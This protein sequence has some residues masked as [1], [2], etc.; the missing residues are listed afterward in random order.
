MG[1]ASGLAGVAFESGLEPPLL[2][3]VIENQLGDV[4]GALLASARRAMGT[5]QRT[6]GAPAG[7]AASGGTT[8]GRGSDG[9]PGAWGILPSPPG[10]RLIAV[11]ACLAAGRI[12]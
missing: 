10:R 11:A 5:L 7:E 3:M 4:H 12:R 9:P 2:M 8:P 6:P 1:D